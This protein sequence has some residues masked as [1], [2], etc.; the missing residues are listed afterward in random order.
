MFSE[1]LDTIDDIIKYMGYRARQLAID[2]ILIKEFYVKEWGTLSVFKDEKDGESYSSI[3]LLNHLRGNN[4]YYKIWESLENNI[5]KTI[6]SLRECNI[7][8]YLDYKRIPNYVV[9]IPIIKTN[10][11]KKIDNFYYNKFSDNS[12][13]PYINHI[14]EGLI[15]LKAIEEKSCPNK[16]FEMYEAFCLHPL[17]QED[18]NL[19]ESFNENYSIYNSILIM[20]MEY[21]NI[22]NSYLSKDT[23]NDIKDIKLS[24]I[25][26]VNKMLVADKIQNYKDLIF[27]NRKHER[28]DELVNYFENWLNILNINRELF[29]R[30]CDILN[31][32]NIIKN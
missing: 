26:Y 22:A 17:F 19:L 18:N 27:F 28:F 8:K 12:N 25:S 29:N 2:N 9:D 30:Q 5:P 32:F 3:Y 4:M 11:Y 20:A 1:N 24:P 21:R 31:S 15:V 6:I 14:L 13:L 7:Y 16:N 23:I 10:S